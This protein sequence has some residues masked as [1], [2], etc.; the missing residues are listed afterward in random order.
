MST[1]RTHR[2]VKAKLENRHGEA[3][4]LDPRRVMLVAASY[5]LLS[6][7]QVLNSFKLLPVLIPFLCIALAVL[8]SNKE[9]LGNILLPAA[10]LAFL[11]W[12]FASTLWSDSPAIT[13]IQSVATAATLVI[14][15]ILGTHLPLR[16]ILAGFVAGA[17][18]IAAVS[19]A[20]GVA[21]PSYGL[22]PAGYQGG[23]LRGLY[24]HRNLLAEVL[25]PAAIAA[26]AL[27]TEGSHR[28]LR[29][30]A[31]LAPLVGTIFLTRSSTAIGVLVAVIA[32]A[33]LLAVIRR[34]KR[35]WRSL[36]LVTS[37]IAGAFMAVIVLANVSTLFALLQRD[38]TLTG[39]TPIW[40]AVTRLIAQRPI[41]GYGWGAVWGGGA[42]VRTFVTRS[43][44]FEVDSAHSGYLELLLQIGAIGFMLFAFVLAGILLRGTKQV[45]R[46]GTPQSTFAPLLIVSVLIY[47]LA[48]ASMVSTLTLLVLG[49]MAAHLAQVRK[50][51]P[52]NTTPVSGAPNLLRTSNFL[53]SCGASS[54]RRRP[55]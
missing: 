53:V 3:G 43:V 16:E 52:A 30:L 41:N 25:T 38:D 49:V 7:P 26:L 24:I 20:L 10:V 4:T 19:I 15:T 47:N 32:L 35:R 12:T 46:E 13:A 11:A 8:A 5:F 29:K 6:T 21:M 42:P 22:M 40:D 50:L 18:I 1:H 9:K 23:A 51:Q 14:A 28:T 37:A 36:A 45:I 54:Y 34:V 31:Y 55:N 33:V 2:T 48:E 39:R 17:L 27:P 44:L